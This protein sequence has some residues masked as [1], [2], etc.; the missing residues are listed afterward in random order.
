MA[1]Y[2]TGDTVTVGFSTGIA[3]ETITV[4]TS[5]KPTGATFLTAG[6]FT[7]LGS[8]DYLVSFTPDVAGAWY[9]RWT[10]DTSG[11]EFTGNWDIDQNT[12][13]TGLT[14]TGGVTRKQLRRWVGEAI[15]DCIVLTATDDG[16]NQ[17]FIDDNNLDGPNNAYNG[18]DL[19]VVGGTALNRGQRRRITSSTQSASR[20][21]WNKPLPADTAEG[22]EAELWN[23]RGIGIKATEV[24]NA[25][26]WALAAASKHVLIP[27]QAD[28]TDTFDQDSPRITLPAAITRGMYQ[29]SWTDGEDV[30]RTIDRAN[31]PYDE[32]WY[33]DPASGT[34]IIGGSYRSRMDGFTVT[35]SGFGIPASLSSDS[36]TTDVDPEWLVAEA[37]RRVIAQIRIRNPEAAG[38]LPPAWQESDRKRP[39]ASGRG[40]P[41]TVMFKL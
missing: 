12:S 11:E 15:G 3:G 35:V 8:G 28:V 18:F 22:D 29:V 10:G 26:D 6:D 33:Y 20:V 36:D 30:V 27:I 7:D 17:S 31:D 13:T 38:W 21:N 34:V 23:V 39:Y 5:R 16:T 32:G 4:N 9:A 37:T 14:T 41:N 24:N 25:I 19:Y 2:L 1:V 40:Y